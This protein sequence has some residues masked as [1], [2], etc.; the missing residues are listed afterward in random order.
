MELKREVILWEVT[1]SSGI[2]VHVL[3]CHAGVAMSK[4]IQF[5]NT[6]PERIDRVE[7]ISGSILMDDE[8]MNGRHREAEYAE[9]IRIS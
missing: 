7:R 1:A 8:I 2:T 4:A 5:W 3:A 9:N 6:K